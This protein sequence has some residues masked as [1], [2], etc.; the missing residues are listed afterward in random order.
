M[1]RLRGSQMPSVSP[2]LALSVVDYLRHEAEEYRLQVPGLGDNMQA[3]PQFDHP[4]HSA[5]VV[6][7]V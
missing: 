6:L 3:A 7:P 2:P 5:Q 1:A 4:L